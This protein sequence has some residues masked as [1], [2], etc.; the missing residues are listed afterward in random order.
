MLIFF[1]VTLNV[2]GQNLKGTVFDQET[3][4]PISYVTIGILNKKGGTYA[5]NDGRFQYKPICYD[6]T[7]SLRFSC[8]GYKPITFSLVELNEKSATKDLEI[9][10]DKKDTGIKEVVVFSHK[11]KII[12]LGNELSNRHIGIS[13]SEERESGIVLKNNKKLYLNNVSFKLAHMSKEPDSLLIRLNFYN[14]KNEIPTDLLLDKPIYFMLSKELKKDQFTLEIE[15]FGVVVTS[16]FAATIEVIK[17]FGEGS[18]GFAG[19]F[20]GSPTI[21]KDGK[22]GKWN[23]PADIKKKKRKIYQSMIVGAKMEK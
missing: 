7:D 12:G 23:N 9:Y 10:L 3:K 1:S 17:K 5:D 16:D 22:Q 18:I 8:I 11:Y 15:K 14:I 4:L 19:W 21:F 20:T 2:S 13:A 6:K